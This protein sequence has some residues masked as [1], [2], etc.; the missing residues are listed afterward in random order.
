MAH[1]RGYVAGSK[2]EA[3]RL[4]GKASGIVTRLQT[5]GWDVEVAA[6]HMTTRGPDGQDVASIELVHHAT[7]ERRHIAFVNLTTGNPD[8]TSLGGDK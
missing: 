3:S 1:F 4:G 7:G 5:W 8:A 2:G 6:R